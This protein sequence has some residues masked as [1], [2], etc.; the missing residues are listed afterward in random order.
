MTDEKPALFTAYQQKRIDLFELQNHH[1]NRIADALETM[2]A[3][4]SERGR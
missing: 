4:E 3:M 2:V 1:L